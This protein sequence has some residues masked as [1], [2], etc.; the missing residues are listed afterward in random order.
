M[1]MESNVF[2]FNR[3]WR[4]FRFDFDAFVSRYGISLLVMSSLGLS[5]EL[6]CGFFSLI[7]GGE[8]HGMW[9]MVRGVMFA[10]VAAIV[11]ITA[12]AKLYGYVTD[13]KE[14][15]AFLMLPA[16]RLEKYISMVL[17]TGV[18][19]PFIFF[20]VYMG[21]DIMVCMIDPTCGGSIFNYLFCN[22][23]IESMLPMGAEIPVEAQEMFSQI[24][25]MASPY[26]MLDDIFQAALFFLLG[27]I[28]FKTSKTGKTLGCLILFSISLEAL[29]TPIIGL[30][31]FG[32]IHGLSTID[33]MVTTPDQMLDVFPIFGW[34]FRNAKIIDTVSDG[35]LNCLLL[36]LIWLRIKKMKH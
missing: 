10:V 25:S 6:F 21:L 33:T 12:P 31:F 13:R 11:L 7:L 22:E 2:N 36:F 29:L 32:S 34:F 17:I 16:S 9:G 18:V 8:W 5:A 35:A 24:R 1:T 19:V 20:T 23:I 26:I 28:V 3:F 4:Y 14:G 27:A 15:S 30:I